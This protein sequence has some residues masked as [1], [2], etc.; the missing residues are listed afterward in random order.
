MV[1]LFDLNTVKQRYCELLKF[2]TSVFYLNIKNIFIHVMAKLN[3]QHRSSVSHDPSEIILICRFGVQEAVSMLYFCG[4]SDQL[5]QDYLMKRKEQHLFEI[6][7]FCNISVFT[8]TLLT[9][10]VLNE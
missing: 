5:F 9:D 3:F 4:N 8:S 7:I 6:E 2:K 10:C 1:H